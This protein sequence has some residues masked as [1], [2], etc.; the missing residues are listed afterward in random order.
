MR[1]VVESIVQ[2]D[3]LRLTFGFLAATAFTGLAYRASEKRRGSGLEQ[4]SGDGKRS[5]LID[6]ILALFRIP[7]DRQGYY[8]RQLALLDTETLLRLLRE[9]GDKPR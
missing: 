1:R 2:D 3:G 9:M 6:R 4:S 8:S 7:T 5:D